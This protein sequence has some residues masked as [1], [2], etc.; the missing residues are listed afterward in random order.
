MRRRLATPLPCLALLAAACFT[1]RGPPTDSAESTTGGSDPALVQLCADNFERRATIVQAQCQCQVD[2]NLYPDLATCVAAFGGASPQSACTCETYG[3]Y[4]EVRAGLECA[5]PIQ[6]TMLSCL[7]GVSCKDDTTAFDACNGPYLTAISNCAGPP[8]ELL[9]EVELTCEMAA[10]YACGSG[11]TIPETWKCDLKVDC[12]DRSDETDCEK[13]YVCGDGVTFIPANYRCDTIPDCPD[14]ADEKNCPTF[15]CTNGNTI[16]AFL[17]CDTMQ[18]CMDGSDEL[19][20]PTFMC[21]D[22]NTMILETMACNGYPDCPDGSDEAVCPTVQ[23]SDG[24]T[25]PKFYECDY[26]PDCPLGEDEEGCP[27]FFCISGA[28]QP[29]KANCD[30]KQDCS[31]GEDEEYCPFRCP[32]FKIDPDLVCDG[33]ND[34]PAG[35]DEA[36]CM[37]P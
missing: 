11:E 15:M 17:R 26:Q 14:S 24:T 25:V 7:T 23:C 6:T 29:A 30:G 27:P 12:E 37:M 8:K 36:N 2:R 22:G 18:D 31:M 1:D 10:P 28:Q 9:G 13:S 20:C 16:P 5:A 21:T 32:G 34:C 33:T 35:E 3:A 4:P 19:S